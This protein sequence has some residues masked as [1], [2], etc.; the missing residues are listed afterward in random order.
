MDVQVHKHF[1]TPEAFYYRGK[2]V[3]GGNKAFLYLYANGKSAVRVDAPG[4]TQSGPHYFQGFASSRWAHPGNPTGSWHNAIS[5]RSVILHYA[6][7]RLSDVKDKAKRS[8]PAKFAGENREV[9]R[10]NCFVIDF[11]ADAYFAASKGDS[12]V[13]EFYF[14]RMVLSEGAPIR[15]H[16]PTRGRGDGWCTLSD[17]PRFTFLMEKIGLMRRFLL[18]QTLLRQHERAIRRHIGGVPCV[19]QDATL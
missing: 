11:D 17:V 6:Y 5:D 15:C 12:A 4:V 2:Y 9:I 13:E 3:L 1:I 19:M 10:Q 7:T 18:P 8:C 16:D 14:H